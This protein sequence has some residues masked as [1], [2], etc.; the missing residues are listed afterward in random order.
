MNRGREIGETENERKGRKGRG[1]GK[2]KKEIFKKR[3][4]RKKERKPA[5]LPAQA[6]R[7]EVRAS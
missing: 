5:S 3:E 2:K 7:T 1:E 6:L 4:R